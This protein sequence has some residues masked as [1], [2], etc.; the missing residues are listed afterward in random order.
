MEKK[1]KA[2]LNTMEDSLG[3]VASSS[4]MTGLEPTPPMTE[5]ELT[6][7]SALGRVPLTEKILRD[8]ENKKD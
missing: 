7:Y 3:G 2:N 6:S 5:F 1:K 4:D 8:N